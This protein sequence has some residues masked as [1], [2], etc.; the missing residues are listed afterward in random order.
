MTSKIN[1]HKFFTI[2]TTLA[3]TYS[4]NVIYSQDLSS[5]VRL[6]GEITNPNSDKITI[7]GN[8]YIKVIDVNTNGTFDD[9]L[10]IKEGNFTFYDTKESTAMYLAPGYRLDISLDGKEFDETLKYSGIERNQIILMPVTFY[11]MKRTQ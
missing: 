3:L 9:T 2:L 4:L 6:S 11:S 5:Y 1:F 8:G 7:R 10:V